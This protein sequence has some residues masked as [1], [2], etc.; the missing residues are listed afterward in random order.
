[1]AGPVALPPASFGLRQRARLL[2]ARGSRGLEV[3][4]R[5]LLGRDVVIEVDP[6]ARIVLH[7]G[8]VIGDGTRLYAR[9]GTLTVGEGAVLGERCRLVAL[10][11]VT[12]GTRAVLGD[13]VV[14][15][16]YSLR[17]DE[18]ERPLREQGVAASPI[19][20]GDGA[21]VGHG[22]CLLSGARI[23]AGATVGPHEVVGT[24]TRPATPV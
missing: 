22:A 21:R 23:A 3:H 17:T 20:I 10:D 8:C 14:L 4:G 9:G 7:D 19:G 24:D 18:V 16:D 1:M 2:R 13:G 11:S 12:I 6:G 15:A 5:P